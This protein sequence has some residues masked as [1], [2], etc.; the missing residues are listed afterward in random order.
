WAA[1]LT[2]VVFS[3]ADYVTWTALRSPIWGNGEQQVISAIQGGGSAT[4]GANHL[5][6]DFAS[7]QYGIDIANFINAHPHLQVLLS[8]FSSWA[9]FPHIKNQG[10]VIF[11]NQSDFKAALLNPRGRVNA[12]LT[13]PVTKYSQTTDE[14]TVAYPTMWGGGVPWAKLV[15]QFPNGYRLYAVLP[16]AP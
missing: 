9:A 7:L 5:Q 10:Q 3:S 13:V 14:I 8:S 4:S 2:C 1:V 12:I 11:S 15:H 6:N 16:S